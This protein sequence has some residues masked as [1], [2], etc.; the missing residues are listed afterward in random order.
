MICGRRGK[1]DDPAMY[2]Y[3]SSAESCS[4]KYR[5]WAASCY[6]PSTSLHSLD[7]L[8]LMNNDLKLYHHGSSACAAKV[9]LVLAEKNLQWESR[10]LD[11]LK[12]EQFN[13][14]YL[15]L[16]PKAVVPTLVH[17]GHVITES[18]IICE[19]LE[20]AF[21]NYPLY[22]ASA[23]EKASARYWT[24]AV[25]EELHPA[26]SALTYVV[27]HRHTILRNGV[28]SF[29]DFINNGDAAGKAA[30][31]MKWQWINEGINAPGAADKIRLYVSYLR[32]MESALSGNDWLLGKQFSI[33][34]VVMAPYVNRLN[35]LAMSPLWENGKLP[36]V[37]SWFARL[38][39]RSSF[40]QAIIDWVPAD[41]REEMLSN[42]QK[43]WP[44]ISSIEGLS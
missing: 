7:V 34:D 5:L 8:S 32:K 43:S 31:L 35:A 44:Q 23:L 22:P 40:Q 14:D 10:Y 11:I 13:P 39:Q 25:G 37:A 18:T 17:E 41:L 6:N 27:S 33:A 38:Q 9:R 1:L 26:C 15:R 29:D 20:D 2:K 28:G 36:A 3:F 42:G 24:K 21:P 4:D 16:N 12:G 19:Y 30:R